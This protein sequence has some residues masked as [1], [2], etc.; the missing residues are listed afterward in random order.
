MYRRLERQTIESVDR[1]FKK[2]I[3]QSSIGKTDRKGLKYWLFNPS[4]VLMR[5]KY[6]KHVCITIVLGL[7]LS[8]SIIVEAHRPY[9]IKQGYI[10]SPSG[11]SV[12]VEKLYGDG[13]FYADPVKVQLRNRFGA[14]I[15]SAKTGSDYYFC[16]NIDYCWV[17]VY[18]QFLVEPFKLDADSINWDRIPKIPED[19]RAS[20]NKYLKADENWLANSHLGY[21]SYKDKSFG[22]IPE[23]PLLKIISPVII[24]SLNICGYLFIL[25]LS[26]LLT[27]AYRC[28]L[29]MVVRQ[30]WSAFLSLLMQ[31]L[32]LLALVLIVVILLVTFFIITM[33]KAW[34]IPYSILVI[35]LGLYWGS[36]VKLMNLEP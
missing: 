34:P 13:I 11:E 30:K 29:Q 24:L 20:L 25:G 33:Y 3:E 9:A 22:F 15:A 14:V 16:P 1:N 23:N 2:S 21:P 36:R 4:E 31:C 35:G 10:K 18:G 7:F 8:G 12:I 27:I 32:N 6:L 26:F 28:F 17:F 5:I 19:F